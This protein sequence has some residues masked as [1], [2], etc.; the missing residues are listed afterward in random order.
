MFHIYT[1]LY[2]MISL[3]DTI[4]QWEYD[5]FLAQII[6]HYA[7]R[8]FDDILRKYNKALVLLLTGNT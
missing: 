2:Q 1:I 6:W 5:I 8:D 4:L 7:D 3:G